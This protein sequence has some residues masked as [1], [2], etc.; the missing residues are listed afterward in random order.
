M[1][2][3]HERNKVGAVI[4]TSKTGKRPGREILSSGGQ[5]RPMSWN[6]RIQLVLKLEHAS[7]SHGRPVKRIAESHPQ[8]SDSTALESC[9]ES[10]FLMSSQM[11]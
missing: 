9:R 6:S 5:K 11:S 10:A 8:I 4:R 2:I 1:V 7:E 3:E